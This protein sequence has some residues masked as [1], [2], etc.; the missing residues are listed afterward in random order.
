MLAQSYANQHNKVDSVQ[1][2]QC[3]N[4]SRLRNSCCYGKATLLDLAFLLV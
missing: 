4:V 2:V 1:Y 3:Y